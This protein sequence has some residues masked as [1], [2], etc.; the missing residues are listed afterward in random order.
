MPEGKFLGEIV[1]WT[2]IAAIVV[3]I[4]MNADNFK[5]AIGSLTSFWSS[6]TS[7]FTGSGY[8]GSSFGKVGG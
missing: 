3:L 6:E 2:I 4:V 5:T 8:N 7:M 1:G